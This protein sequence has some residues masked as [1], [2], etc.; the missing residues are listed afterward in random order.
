MLK[1]NQ[2]QRENEENRGPQAETTLWWMVANQ[3]DQMYVLI[4]PRMTSRQRGHCWRREQQLWQT[5][6]WPH[7]IRV[8]DRGL[9]MQTTQI[10]C[11]AACE[12]LDMEWTSGA[13]EGCSCGSEFL[14]ACSCRRLTFTINSASLS[15]FKS[16]FWSS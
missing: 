14:V 6:M 11:E 10:V 7:G 8:N 9:H 3:V 5:A 2:T 1:S 16:I 15:R 12:S 13:V 4:T